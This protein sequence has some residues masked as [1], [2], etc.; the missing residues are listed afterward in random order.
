MFKY[1][2]LA[3]CASAIAAPT[4]DQGNCCVTVYVYPDG[5]PAPTP[6]ANATL[7]AGTSGGSEDSNTDSP[8]TGSSSSV[9]ISSDTAASGTNSDTAASGTNAQTTTSGN[10]TGSS[11]GNAAS[12]VAGAGGAVGTGG[13]SA[14]TLP[15]VLP[16]VPAFVINEDYIHAPVDDSPVPDD[17]FIFSP[18]TPGVFDPV[19]WTTW[20]NAIR[21]GGNLG[22][23]W[24]KVK[25]GY[26]TWAPGPHMPDGQDPNNVA[27]ENIVM[28]QFRDGWTLDLRGVTFYIP[29]T[30][31]NVNTRPSC[32]IY[33]NGSPSLTVL[34]GTIW[35]DKGELYTQARITATS[36]NADGSV[37]ATV[38]VEAGY[39]VATWRT[40]GPRNIG[41]V[42][43]SNPDHYVD[44]GCNG[45][46]YNNFNFDNLDSSRT[47]SFD[48]SPGFGFKQD[49]VLFMS[50]LVN[51]NIAVS[52]EHNPD[53][54]VKGLTTNSVLFSIGNGDDITVPV[55]GGVYQVNPPPRPGFAPRALGPL[56]SWSNVNKGQVYNTPGQ[57]LCP[58]PGSMFQFSGSNKDLAPTY[59]IAPGWS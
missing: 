51:L 34:G 9:P 49:I 21:D 8:S 15:D 40:M 12:S 11:T 28:W 48:Y 37:H 6:I 29:I 27:G 17:A 41:C 33:V 50:I 10:S 58:V 46:K 14:L 55:Y 5:S 7:A 43:D 54:V 38:V 32:V 42:D 18:A 39:D 16:G 22:T 24:L 47:F 59:S 30:P 20:A 25:P 19:A 53:L 3:L 1:I 36:N 57:P 31:E 52:N 44:G 13:P 23:K 4:L 2:L 35:I 26:Y 45:W 56:I